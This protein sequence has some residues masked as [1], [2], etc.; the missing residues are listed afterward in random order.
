MDC[1][2][3][4]NGGWQSFYEVASQT[5]SY[6]RWHYAIP[7]RFLSGAYEWKQTRDP[8]PDGAPVCTH[9]VARDNVPPG[10]PLA[11]TFDTFHTAS[12][13]PADQEFLSLAGNGYHTRIAG[14][15]S[16]W[17]TRNVNTFGTQQCFL[18]PF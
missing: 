10:P 5:F 12:R 16:W 15:D 14:R 3:N 11:P 6:E 9:W 17:A 4:F 13:V 8:H 1:Q 7:Y 2:V 18:N